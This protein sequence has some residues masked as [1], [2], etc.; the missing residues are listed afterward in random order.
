MKPKA[1]ST[2]CSSKEVRVFGGASSETRRQHLT[3]PPP[4][5]RCDSSTSCTFAVR[6]AIKSNTV[7]A[8]L[9]SGVSESPPF[10]SCTPLYTDLPASLEVRRGATTLPHRHA[11]STPSENAAPEEVE[12]GTAMSRC[13]DE[14]HVHEASENASVGGI[15]ER[16]PSP[17][18]RSELTKE[19][20]EASFSRSD[21]ISSSCS[22]ASSQDALLSSSSSSTGCACGCGDAC[23]GI[24]CIVRS[25]QSLCHWG[26]E[27][28]SLSVSPSSNRPSDPQYCTSLW[29]N[30]KIKEKKE[31]KNA[32]EKGDKGTE[33]TD[34]SVAE[35][36]AFMKKLS[37]QREGKNK[38]SD[39]TL[40]VFV[41]SSAMG[42]DKNAYDY[43]KALHNKSSTLK[44]SSEKRKKCKK[45]E[46]RRAEK[47]KSISPRSG[48]RPEAHLS[49][50]LPLPSPP[51]AT[52]SPGETRL[53]MLST[54]RT[55][56]GRDT[57]RDLNISGRGGREGSSLF[58]HGAPGCS[59]SSFLSSFP[60]SP[61]TPSLSFSET[62]RTTSFYAG[63]E[64]VKRKEEEEDGK[65]WNPTTRMASAAY[66][67]RPLSPLSFLCQEDAIAFRGGVPYTSSESSLLGVDDVGSDKPRWKS[68]ASAIHLGSGRTRETAARVEVGSFSSDSTITG[69]AAVPSETKRGPSGV[70]WAP[71]PP[72]P[73]VEELYA[74]AMHI[75][76]Y[77]E[78]LQTHRKTNG[79][80]PKG[81]LLGGASSTPE[82][83]ISSS[84]PT[85]ERR[86]LPERHPPLQ[87]GL[88]T[89]KVEGPTPVWNTSIEVLQVFFQRY[90]P[91]LPFQLH[92]S[93]DAIEG[94]SSTDAM[95][96]SSFPLYAEDTA[97]H[98]PPSG[99]KVEE[100]EWT[101]AAPHIHSFSSASTSAAV[102]NHKAHPPHPHQASEEIPQRSP[103]EE[104]MERGTTRIQPIQLCLQ[105]PLKTTTPYSSLLSVM[106]DV[107]LED[108]DPRYP[109]TTLILMDMHVRVSRHMDIGGGGNGDE[110]NEARASLY[111][112]ASSFSMIPLNEWRRQREVGDQKRN[113][114]QRGV[115]LDCLLTAPT[116]IV[117]HAYPRLEKHTDVGGIHEVDARNEGRV[118]EEKENGEIVRGQWTLPVGAHRNT[119]LLPLPSWSGADTGVSSGF[120]LLTPCSIGRDVSLFP[121]S[122]SGHSPMGEVYN[123]LHAQGRS[124]VGGEVQT[125]VAIFI[126]NL[127]DSYRCRPRDVPTATIGL[128]TLILRRVVCSPHDLPLLCGVISLDEEDDV[129]REQ[130]AS[131][132]PEGLQDSRVRLWNPSQPVDGQRAPPFSAASIPVSP[133]P[134]PLLVRRLRME[135]CPFT[136]VHMD[137]L[138]SAVR[139]RGPRF[140]SAVSASDA[141][142]CCFFSHMEELQ[143][144][145]P[146]TQDCVEKLL[147]VI[148]EEEVFIAAAAATES[149]VVPTTMQTTTS[150][151]TVIH[152]PRTAKNDSAVLR[153]GKEKRGTEDVEDM[154]K[155]I[156]ARISPFSLQVIRLPQALL[157]VARRDRF[158]LAHPNIRV[159]AL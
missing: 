12:A 122:S 54:A 76:R 73:T 86:H 139:R 88:A 89:E 127:L 60:S 9:F 116:S 25:L 135:Q 140:D 34:K 50:S 47:K 45:T 133:S 131:S 118:T 30:G 156:E 75:R 40:C 74:D 112:G 159:E 4:L 85:T 1:V 132:P 66:R 28:S 43:S 80:N 19:N 91:F 93:R 42:R 154:G 63:G 137:E 100:G 82:R 117:L 77:G 21:T 94:Q 129:A 145:G 7:S 115:L 99:G 46:E 79:T 38:G 51:V 78:P 17:P 41:S 90:A 27:E 109:I 151:E 20:L 26:S 84:L 92:V 158:L 33:D 144:S 142:S 114:L 23:F 61:V 136:A 59:T 3:S 126:S 15:E 5:Q 83:P 130:D 70:C 123:G 147:R 52:S 97:P 157:S 24:S 11:S 39:R 125:R 149:V 107:L 150:N 31:R 108:C 96:R 101:R 95:P 53:G 128:H 148:E 72:F 44:K 102:G 152:R 134:P 113:V 87:E 37:W 29:K 98:P 18:L 110:E 69:G 143:L 14:R 48:G 32:E 146:L 13:I 67:G 141:E 103:H 49:I 10:T 153:E 6:D 22:T 111:H 62:L 124:D 106:E 105:G 8:P 55:A 64:G 57:V 65:A 155:D 16:L 58:S 56:G 120:G 104:G 119:V 71:L 35:K 138:V 121:P 81:M 2:R 36:N 68:T